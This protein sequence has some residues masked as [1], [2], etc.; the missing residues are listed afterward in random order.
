MLYNVGIFAVMHTY[1]GNYGNKGVAIIF[2]KFL[3]DPQ[4]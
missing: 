2:L 4:S 1:I 3:L